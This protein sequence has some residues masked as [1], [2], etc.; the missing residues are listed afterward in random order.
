MRVLAVVLLIPL[1][2]AGSINAQGSPP[3]QVSVAVT[4][5]NVR[6]T[7][8]IRADTLLI[9]NR[10]ERSRP[11]GHAIKSCVKAG[12]GGLL[13]AGVMTCTIT[14][15]LPLGKLVATGI[16]HDVHRYSLVITGGTRRYEG[17]TGPLFVRSVAADG[18][19]RLTFTL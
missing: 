6:D 5:V 3:E 12:S 8:S 17:V 19:R 9:W 18:I 1:S 10:N 16:V 2:L 13:G 11:I 14:I 7:P 4:T 15:V